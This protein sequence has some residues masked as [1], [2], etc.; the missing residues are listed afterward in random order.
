LKTDAPKHLPDAARRWWRAMATEY[1]I[2]DGGGRALLTAAAEARG[3]A[4]QA[5]ALIDRDGLV[6]TD[7]FGQPQPHPAVRIEQQA[8][9]QQIR[10]LKALQLD[11]EPV[12]SPGRPSVAPGW[13]GGR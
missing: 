8:R 4:E 9:E 7:R 10:A 11:L 2:T 12:K 13:A 5:R 6:V 3:R 1:G